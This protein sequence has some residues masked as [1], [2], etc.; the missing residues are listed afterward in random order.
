MNPAGDGL[1]A[2]AAHHDLRDREGAYLNASPKNC[3]TSGA[4]RAPTPRPSL[5]KESTLRLFSASARLDSA[6]SGR[7][8]LTQK[9]SAD[10][11]ARPAR[12]TVPSCTRRAGL[13]ADCNVA[14]GFLAHAA[15]AHVP[16]SVGTSFCLDAPHRRFPAMGIEMAFR[17]ADRLSRETSKTGLRPVGLLLVE[18]LPTDLRPVASSSSTRGV[19]GRSV[20]LA[21]DHHRPAC[22]GMLTL[23]L[24]I[25][26]APTICN[27]RPLPPWLTA[28][29]AH[30]DTAPPSSISHT[31][32]SALLA[33]A[34]R[35]PWLLRTDKNSRAPR[36][37]ASH[38]LRRSSPASVALIDDGSRG[39]LAPVCTPGPRGD[40]FP[41]AVT[42]RASCPPELP[43][44]FNPFLPRPPLFALD[45]LGLRRDHRITKQRRGTHGGTTHVVGQPRFGER[46]PRRRFSPCLGYSTRTCATPQQRVAAD[47]RASPARG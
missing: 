36:S 22:L 24:R 43:V 1:M 35:R 41:A 38:D 33:R 40:P 32:F 14:F 26:G 29:L 21:V 16:C 23:R 28:S 2:P 5:R 4:S 39:S 3:R 11:H 7:G 9:R 46:P 17:T 10:Q 20:V 37:S 12:R 42:A 44:R 30:A 19:G 47:R 8:S 45:K 31:H 27:A 34:S 25:V 15:K 13:L 18:L 6:A